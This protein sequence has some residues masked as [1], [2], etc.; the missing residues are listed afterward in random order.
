MR[1]TRN[2]AIS[3]IL[4]AIA[5]VSDAIPSSLVEQLKSN[6]AEL[7]KKVKRDHEQNI[8]DEEQV[9]LNNVNY[10]NPTANKRGVNLKSNQLPLL[11]EWDRKKIQDSITDNYPSSLYGND[12]DWDD[13][14]IGEYEKGFRYGTN[15]DKIDEALENAILKSEIYGEPAALNQYRYYGAGGMDSKRRRRRNVS[16]A[17]KNKLSNRLKRD[18]ELSPEDILAILSLLD[19]DRPRSHSTPTG[20]PTWYSFEPQEQEE[21]QDNDENWLDTPVYPHVGP[22]NPTYYYDT[23]NKHERW[24]PAA[25]KKKRFM[26]AKKRMDNYYTLP[27]LLGNT[28][29]NPN[30][31]L[32]QRYML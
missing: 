32:Y 25:D 28:E 14:T 27:E 13:K 7:T 1:L 3:I 21:N 16:K 4:F 30:V 31:P 15:K 24:G 10:Y 2:C 23:A 12:E 22:I 20:H 6:D 8:N 11:T 9:P 29:V 5:I 17:F 26:V 18:T 19:N